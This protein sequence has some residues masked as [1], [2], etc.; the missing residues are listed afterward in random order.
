MIRF[1]NRGG[2]ACVHRSFALV[3]AHSGLGTGDERSSWLIL[4]SRRVTLANSDDARRH[5]SRLNRVNRCCCML[6]R[7]LWGL[8]NENRRVEPQTR[9]RQCG[10]D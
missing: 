9:Y 2:F 10:A 3:G 4:E 5:R 8:Q 1:A 7:L 6:R